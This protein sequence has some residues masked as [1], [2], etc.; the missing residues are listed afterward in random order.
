MQAESSTK[1]ANPRSGS[2]SVKNY[3]PFWSHAHDHTASQCFLL[4]LDWSLHRGRCEMALL[5]QLCTGQDLA[6]DPTFGPAGNA[7]IC[8]GNSAERSLEGD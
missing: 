6:F 5:I 8:F 4:H 1:T 3:R 7:W 2:R